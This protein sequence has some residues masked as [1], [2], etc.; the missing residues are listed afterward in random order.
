[1][2]IVGF[3]MLFFKQY[4]EFWSKSLTFNPALIKSI[5]YIILFINNSKSLL[6]ILLMTQNHYLYLTRTHGKRS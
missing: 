1:M 5:L 3:L 6:N 4:L 2:K